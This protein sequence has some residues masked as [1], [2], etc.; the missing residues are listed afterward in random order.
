MTAYELFETV[1][2]ALAVA[3]AARY[4]IARLQ[5]AETT[6]ARAERT[7]CAAGCDGCGGCPP[8]A[9]RR[10]RFVARAPANRPDEQGNRALSS[11]Q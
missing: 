4:A 3:A 1:A 5:R 10:I 7:G 2:I 9:E 6:A 11:G 8:P